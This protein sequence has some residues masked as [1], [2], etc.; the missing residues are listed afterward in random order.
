MEAYP[1]ILASFFSLHSLKYIVSI[2]SDESIFQHWFADL[3]QYEFIVIHKKDIE[4][5]STDAL[6]RSDPWDV[7]TK[8]EN[9]EYQADNEVGELKM[10]YATD[11]EWDP[12]EIAKERWRLAGY[13]PAMH[14]ISPETRHEIIEGN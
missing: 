13:W 7:P 6:S 12:A 1:E 9:E 3:A 8:E 14:S 11:L 5:V 10:T 4:N 2:K